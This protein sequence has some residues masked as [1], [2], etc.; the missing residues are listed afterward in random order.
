MIL[1]WFEHKEHN[2]HGGIPNFRLLQAC[3]SQTGIKRLL[4]RGEE[5]QACDTH[6]AD[7]FDD[8]MNQGGTNALAAIRSVY[9]NTGQP[10][11][12]LHVGL[13]IMLSQAGRAKK[14]ILVMSAESGWD[15][16]RP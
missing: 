13:H 12:E 14:R 8:S 10:G 2:N 15:L 1:F 4:I 5:V 16:F 9:I 6:R 7:F 3:P 11:R